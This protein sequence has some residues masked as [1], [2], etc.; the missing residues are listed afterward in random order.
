MSEPRL[1][2][3][4]V[5]PALDPEGA[6]SPFDPHVAGTP[7]LGLDL[8]ESDIDILCHAPEPD[9]FAATVWRTQS[10]RADFA[11]WQWRGAGRPVIA[12]FAAFGWTIELFAAPEPVRRQP[13]WR[14]FAV[15]RRLLDRGGLA[16][17]ARVM[18]LRRAGMKTEP[19]FAAVLGLAGDPYRV[20]L[21]LDAEDDETLDRRLALAGC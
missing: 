1:A 10:G 17:R 15:E 16:L 9:R 11:L 8:P 7:P 19:A 21:D 18:A 13:G 4:A 5:L 14:H 2:W 3:T 20:L 6:L 12:R